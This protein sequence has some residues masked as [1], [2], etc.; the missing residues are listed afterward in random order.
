MEKN[1][2]IAEISE[3]IDAL[4]DR[5]IV[6]FKCCT[7]VV[8]M[9][10]IL[11]LMV[12]K[13]RSPKILPAIVEAINKFS[14]DSTPDKLVFYASECPADETADYFLL[15][16]DLVC[17]GAFSV[18]LNAYF[19]LADI[20]DTDKLKGELS[21]VAESKLKSAYNPNDE[22]AIFIKDLLEMFE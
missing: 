1:E 13:F 12:F 10:P 22:K 3:H 14:L 2:T 9:M 6:R 7:E 11:D 21:E 19:I 15:W 8:E 17:L 18:A 20:D 16:I 5:L 4:L